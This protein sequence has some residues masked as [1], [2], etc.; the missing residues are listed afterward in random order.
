M[1]SHL[2]V[3][4]E[5]WEDSDTPKKH[6]YYLFYDENATAMAREDILK[7]QARQ[8]VWCDCEEAGDQVLLLL[9]TSENKLLE[10]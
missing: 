4:Q 1:H 9:P 3:L 10:K 6:Q 2:D 7:S 8:K 5:M